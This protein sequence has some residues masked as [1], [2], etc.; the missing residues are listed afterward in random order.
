MTSPKSQSDQDR[1]FDIELFDPGS[2]QVGK[3]KFQI[4]LSQIRVGKD[5]CGEIQRACPSPSG[6][7]CDHT[8]QCVW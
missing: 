7:V 3:S 6:K 4:N 2:N 1:L 5:L 8:A